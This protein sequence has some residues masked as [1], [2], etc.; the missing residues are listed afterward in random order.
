M[1]SNYE[2][3]VAMF[4]NNAGEIALRKA[5]ESDI[6]SGNVYT[7]EEADQLHADSLEI[8][9]KEKCKLDSFSFLHC[10]K[11]FKTDYV[12]EECVNRLVA[13]KWGKPRLQRYM[14][15]T[16]AKSKV[17]TKALKRLSK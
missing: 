6:K 7:H 15:T 13:A 12:E 10:P 2:G 4:L 14:P 17:V 1:K 5:S 11:H 9:K 8:A 16:K 3:Y